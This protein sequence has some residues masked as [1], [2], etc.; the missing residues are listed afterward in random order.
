[1]A[2]DYTIRRAGGHRR[3]AARTTVQARAQSCFY[4]SG[5]TG[6]SARG[7]IARSTTNIRPISP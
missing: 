2:P 1:M 7:R 3:D 6:P 4:G 5:T